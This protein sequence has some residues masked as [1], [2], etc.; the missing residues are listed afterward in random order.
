MELQCTALNRHP[1]CWLCSLSPENIPQEGL[2]EKVECFCRS[3][4]V[5]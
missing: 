3:L 4:H 1:Q 2:G 5:S